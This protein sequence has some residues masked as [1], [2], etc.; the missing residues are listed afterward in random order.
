MGSATSKATVK[1]IAENLT[2]SE[3]DLTKLN[4]QVNIPSIYLS[5]SEDG[6]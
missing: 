6:I 2:Y 5:R 3:N 4:K 1:N